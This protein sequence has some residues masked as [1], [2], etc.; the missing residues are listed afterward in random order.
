VYYAA[1]DPAGAGLP[2]YPWVRPIAI[3]TENDQAE[4]YGVVSPSAYGQIGFRIDTRV[5][6]VQIST[7]PLFAGWCGAALAADRLAG[8]GDLANS[9]AERGGPWHAPAGTFRRTPEGLQAD[10]EGVAL[11]SLAAEVGLVHAIVNRTAPDAVGLVVHAADAANLI[12]FTV[13]AGHCAL[14]QVTNGAASLLAQADL[15]ELASNSPIALQVRLNGDEVVCSV[16]GR[17]L[18]TATPGSP[19]AGNGVGLYAAASGAASGAANRLLDFEAH[20]ARLLLPIELQAPILAIAPAT[21]LLVSEDFA[22]EPRSLA[23]KATSCGAATWSRR[24][25]KGRIETTGHGEARVIATH[26]EPNP[27][28]TGFTVPWTSP[29]LAELEVEMTVPGEGPGDKH[30]PRGGFVFEQDPDNHLI[31][32][33]WRG[34]EYPGGSVSSFFR[35][36]GFEEIYDAVWTNIGRRAW[37]GDRVRLRVTFDGLQYLVTL[38]GEPVLYR[39]LTDIYPDCPRLQIRQVGLVANWEWG[40]DTGTLFRDFTARGAD[41]TR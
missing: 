20:P 37:Y 27:G 24:F 12:R 34:D 40:D 33:L 26:L 30:K 3:D 18:L 9:A 7:P 6:A 41:G 17:E 31:V 35:I 28:R 32:S 8:A 4:V 5:Y 38:D 11:L 15:P 21:R 19:A 22:G 16:A 29:E 36:G 25:G 39:R 23:D 2:A 1:A 13:A 10:G 14:H